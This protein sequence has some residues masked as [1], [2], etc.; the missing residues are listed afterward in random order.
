M[1][2]EM[3]DLFNYLREFLEAV[4]SQKDMIN[5]TFPNLMLIIQ[6]LA[7][8]DLSIGKFFSGVIQDHRSRTVWT[9]ETL[10]DY[11]NQWAT[12]HLEE[13]SNQER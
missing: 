1:T 6:K 10:R 4:A 2:K 8:T 12:I 11:F 9:I 5:L 7:E 13:G 3:N